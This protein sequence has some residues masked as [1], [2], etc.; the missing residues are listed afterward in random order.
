MFLMPAA[1][2]GAITIDEVMQLRT[3]SAVALSPDGAQVAYAVADR[4]SSEIRIGSRK[5]TDGAAPA[6]SPDGKTVAFLRTGDIWS[7]PAAGGDAVK[8]TDQPRAVQRFAWSPDG[9][10]IAFTEQDEIPISDPTVFEVNDLPFVRL[11]LYDLSARR[12]RPLT[13]GQYSVGGYDQWFPDGISWS[14]DSRRITFSRRPDARAGGHLF[15]DLA[16]V[17]IDGGEP[18][19]LVRRDGMDANPVW[20]PRGDWLGFIST[21]KVDWVTISNFF[22]VSPSTREIRNLTREFDE[23]VKNFAWSG[24]GRKIFFSAG[25]GTSEPIFSL[26]VPD[27]HVRRLTKDGDAYSHLSLSRDGQRAAFVRQNGN[28]PPEVYVTRTDAI[29]PERISDVNPQIQPSQI[30]ETASIRWR[31]FDGME[32][33]GMLVKPVGGH[34]GR[35]Y[36]LLVIPHGGP[37]GVV[38]NTFFPFRN[39][40]LM[41]NRG[42]AVFEPNFRG[43]GNYGERFLRANLDGW[44]VG[45]FRDIMTGI[46]HLIGIGL[47]DPDRLAISGASY[48]GYMAAWSITQTNRFRAAIVGCAVTNL[49]SFIGTTDVR[50]RFEAYLGTDPRRYVRLS[51]MEY[52]DRART[53]SLI[54]HGDQDPRVPLTQGREF[55]SALKHHG[56]PTEFLIYHGE[57]HGLRLARHQ[58]DLMEREVAWLERFTR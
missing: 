31:S 34:S 50:S 26:D 14:P 6:W 16:S 10:Y 27:G 53:P 21:G 11:W 40:W 48:G 55:Y 7:I 39:A 12:S 35:R 1:V 54:W 18:E 28:T 41:A 49:V 37:H 38:T 57:G 19:Y 4:P 24:D 42:W 46:D 22:L 43:S 58:K 23:S 52:V 47:A 13:S 9:K 51:P 15:A 3:V 30:P 8:L 56:V 25:Q 45:D 20:S 29:R 2:Y 44:G 17:S 32:I 33:E 5:L 36:P